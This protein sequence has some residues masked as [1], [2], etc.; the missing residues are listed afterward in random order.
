VTGRSSPRC[1]LTAG[2]VAAFVFRASSS[3]GE[4]RP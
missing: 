4:P 2:I 3:A 1:S